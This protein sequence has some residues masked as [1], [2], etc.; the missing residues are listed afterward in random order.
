MSTPVNQAQH[1]QPVFHQPYQQ[2]YQQ[3]YQQP[4]QHASPPVQAQQHVPPQQPPPAAGSTRAPKAQPLRQHQ[5]MPAA[6]PP[7]PLDWQQEIVKRDTSLMEYHQTVEMLG[8]KVRK[9]EQLI[10]LKDKRIDGARRCMHAPSSPHPAELTR[11][12]RAAGVKL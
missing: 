1:P 2:A 3:P 5:T 8:A 7:P 10:D 12:L 6:P 4:Y 11:K 9:L